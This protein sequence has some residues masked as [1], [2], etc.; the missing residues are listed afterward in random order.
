MFKTVI[1]NPFKGNF[2]KVKIQNAP[3]F[4]WSDSLDANYKKKAKSKKKLV[5]KVATV[6]H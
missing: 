4:Y 5:W 3:I 1:F 6:Q 2:F